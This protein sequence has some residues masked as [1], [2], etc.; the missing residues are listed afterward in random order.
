[1]FC[2]TKHFF[3]AWVKHGSSLIQQGTALEIG[4][5]SVKCDLYLYPHFLY[6]IET[7]R[8]FRHADPFSVAH[9]ENNC[10]KLHI[11]C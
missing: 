10:Y 9:I 3:H 7:D 11:N 4:H 1:M 8:V 6:M 5:P 2:T